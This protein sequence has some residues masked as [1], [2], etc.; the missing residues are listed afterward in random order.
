MFINQ[1]ILSGKYNKL[2]DLNANSLFEVEDSI[3]YS[4]QKK[5][6]YLKNSYNSGKLNKH[7]TR[8]LFYKLVP[9][10][11][12]GRWSGS[13]SG[14]TVLDY[15]RDSVIESNLEYKTYTPIFGFYILNTNR[16]N[17]D[18]SKFG[19][20]FLNNPIGFNY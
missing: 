13:D 19:R 7:I 15:R 14:Q 11:I 9:S 5:N 17:F 10:Y 12:D 6:I 1:N 4:N 2:Y 20:E 8:D 3:K 18:L 16:L